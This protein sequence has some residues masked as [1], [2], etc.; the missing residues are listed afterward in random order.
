MN[1]YLFTLFQANSI[2]RMFCILAFF[3]IEQ[4]RQYTSDDVEPDYYLSK[5]LEL[6]IDFVFNID[7]WEMALLYAVF[8]SYPANTVISFLLS[9][10]PKTFMRSDSSQQRTVLKVLYGLELVTTP[11]IFYVACLRIK[12]VFFPPNSE[13][14]MG[15]ILDILHTGDVSVYKKW[16]AANL[17]LIALSSIIFA[18]LF[19]KFYSVNKK[20]YNS[21]LDAQGNSQR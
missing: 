2:I 12:E 16:D 20:I 4:I 17:G 11:F 9:L 8:I 21:T 5:F 6:D 15:E 18:S 14:L 10:W 13:S 19:W 7:S 3:G 1:K